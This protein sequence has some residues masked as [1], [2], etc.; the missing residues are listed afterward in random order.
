MPFVLEDVKELLRGLI[1]SID[2]KADFSVSLLEGDR[3]GASVT[4]SLRKHSTTVVVPVEHLE[5]AAQF[6]IR[7]AQLRT[8]LKRAIDRMMF[9]PDEIAS[10]K[11]LRGAVVD[12]GFFRP[13]QG[14]RGGRR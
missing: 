12:G 5:A 8:T 2:R 14:N 7:R 6:S 4:M 10:T 13:M 1:R 9:A 11:M 3:P